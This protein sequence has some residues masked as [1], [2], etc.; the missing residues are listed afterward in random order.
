ML[1]GPTDPLFSHPGEKHL[2]CPKNIP[3][4]ISARDADSEN[5]GDFK[6]NKNTLKSRTTTIFGVSGILA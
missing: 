2:L 1:E 3:K 5:F 4:I 6:K